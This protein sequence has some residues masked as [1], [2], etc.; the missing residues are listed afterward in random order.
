MGARKSIA[1]ARTA[2][3][4]IFFCNVKGAVK[5]GVQLLFFTAPFCWGEEI[6]PD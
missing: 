5:A 6:F 4:L 2:G 1:P 3:Y